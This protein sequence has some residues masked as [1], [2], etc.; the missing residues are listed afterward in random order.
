MEV[1]LAEKVNVGEPGVPGV[2]GVPGFEIACD[3]QPL[4]VARVM[5]AENKKLKERS[6]RE[7]IRP[8]HLG[9]KL[10]K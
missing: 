7:F 3:P 9:A 6:V 1:L 4:S 2:P 10:K 8:W 5:T